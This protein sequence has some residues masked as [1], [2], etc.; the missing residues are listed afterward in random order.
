MGGRTDRLSL[1]LHPHS[2][3]C[4]GTSQKILSGGLSPGL[5]VVLGLTNKLAGRVQ[6]LVAEPT[7]DQARPP[8]T[9]FVLCRSTLGGQCA[10]AWLDCDSLLP[11]MHEHGATRSA[12]AL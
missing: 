3:E 8:Q 1:L 11:G 2:P 6:G 9:I 5:L 4:L 10:W 7:N 12:I